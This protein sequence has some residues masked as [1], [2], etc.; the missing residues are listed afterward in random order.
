MT[1]GDDFGKHVLTDGKDVR[2][3]P[4]MKKVLLIA[5]VV[6]AAASVGAIVVLT[7]SILHTKSVW[8]GDA[9]IGYDI[10][11]S[12]G[13][14]SV[15][16]LDFLIS[17]GHAHEELYLNDVTQEQT[18]KVAHPHYDIFVLKKYKEG[19]EMLL[20]TSKPAAGRPRRVI[21]CQDSFMNDTDFVPSSSIV[22]ESL[23][24]NPDVTIERPFE[25]T[26]KPIMLV[27]KSCDLIPKEL[28]KQE[29]STS[30]TLDARLRERRDASSYGN[31]G[32]RWKG[33]L[34]SPCCWG[35]SQYERCTALNCTPPMDELDRAC[36]DYTFCTQCW[37][38]TP[39]RDLP[40]CDC[41]RDLITDLTGMRCPPS[42]YRDCLLY[43]SDLKGI[44]TGH[45]CWGRL[46]TKMY[47]AYHCGYKQV[48]C[49]RGQCEIKPEYC[50]RGKTMVRNNFKCENFMTCEESTRKLGGAQ[51]FRWF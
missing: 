1:S 19:R 20:I 50:V 4:G 39:T 35:C 27:Y 12:S 30:P 8:K 44:M 11:D 42:K 32:G 49:K 25:R 45:R 29:D 26:Y 48:G 15:G 40:H 36:M 38:D 2:S 24:K 14:A 9:I 34:F 16:K 41:I 43:R 10:L 31:W 6:L 23:V 13:K 21:E 22:D 7:A 17:D 5:A 47:E 37:H 18:I 46:V 3:K 51:N 33:S 28:Y